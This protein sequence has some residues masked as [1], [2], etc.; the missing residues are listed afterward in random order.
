MLPA[1]VQARAREAYARFRDDPFYQGLRFK[2]I[3]GHKGVWSVR[4]GLG[5]RAVGRR[6]R[7]EIVW[8][9]IGSH[10]EYDALL[11]QE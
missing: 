6:E 7:D 9:W 11:A 3:A 5:Y 2:E 1:D 10:A 4:I 8:I